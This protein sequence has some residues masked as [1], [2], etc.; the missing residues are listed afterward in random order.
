MSN[1]NYTPPTL[2]ELLDRRWV[3]GEQRAFFEAVADCKRDG[4]R[5]GT[6]AFEARSKRLHETRA[7]QKHSELLLAAH[8]LAAVGLRDFDLSPGER[9]DFQLRLGSDHVGLEVAELVE[10]ESA[11][12]S[13]SA[14]NIRIDIRERLDA[15]RI[16]REA[17]GDRFISLSAWECPKRSLERKIVDEYER[18]I[19]TRLPQM[20]GSRIK[21]ETYPAMTT[22]FVHAQF[23]EFQGGSVDFTPPP[24]LLTRI[25]SFPSRSKCSSENAKKLHLTRAIGYGL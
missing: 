18:L 23:S 7:S 2:D 11:R 21:D 9:P 5:I 6:L 16:L 10:P 24:P 15:D 22:C 13:N 1:T 4:I 12:I 25:R 3:S 20:V 19:R 17:L 8:A 14:E